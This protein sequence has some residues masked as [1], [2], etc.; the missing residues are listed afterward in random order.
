MEGIST[1]DVL[2]APE[3]INTSYLNEFVIIYTE[4]RAACNN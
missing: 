3:G 4:T 1:Q 2:E